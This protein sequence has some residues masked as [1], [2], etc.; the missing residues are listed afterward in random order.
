MHPEQA[1]RPLVESTYAAAAG[2]LDWGALLEQLVE[3]VGGAALLRALGSGCRFPGL[4]AAGGIDA[5]WVDKYRETWVAR[6]PCSCLLDGAALDAVVD[7][8]SSARHI[9]LE[10]TDF[11][12]QWMTPQG[13]RGRRRASRPLATNS[14]RRPA[15]RHR[16]S[17][18]EAG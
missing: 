12:R 5:R 3:T 4:T 7:C 1:F 16:R 15:V 17:T 14:S 8:D 11:C 18:R 9:D 6:D 13:F 2:E 10:T